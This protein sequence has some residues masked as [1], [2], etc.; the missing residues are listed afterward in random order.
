MKKILIFILIQLLILPQAVFAVDLR[1][2]TDLPGLLS[3]KLQLPNHVLQGI[4][5]KSFHPV[6]NEAEI[7]AANARS[8]KEHEDV[9]YDFGRGL[10]ARDFS[11]KDIYIAASVILDE[12]YAN[13]EARDDYIPVLRKNAA[14]KKL[15][16]L[17]IALFIELF[18][19]AE[20]HEGKVLNTVIDKIMKQ[21][22]IE[23]SRAELATANFRYYV[24]LQNPRWAQR[25]WISILHELGHNIRSN[26]IGEGEEQFHD[27]H[28]ASINEFFADLCPYIVCLKKNWIDLLKIIKLKSKRKYEKAKRANKGVLIDPHL[29]SQSQWYRLFR[30]VRIAS[31]MKNFPRLVS[32]FHAA[33]SEKYSDIK[34]FREWIYQ[35]NGFGEKIYKTMHVLPLDEEEITLADLSIADG[36]EEKV[37]EQG[38]RLH[39][40]SNGLG[41]KYLRGHEFVIESLR[42]T[43]GDGYAPQQYLRAFELLET[44]GFLKNITFWNANK[45]QFLYD[46][47][48][49]K[50]NAQ[51][52]KELGVNS[53]II[54]TQ[55]SK[56]SWRR[57]DFSKFDQTLQLINEMKIQGCSTQEIVDEINRRGLGNRWGRRGGRWTVKAIDGLVTRHSVKSV[58][59]P[60]NK[61]VYEFKPQIIIHGR[62]FAVLCQIA[63]M[64]KHNEGININFKI[65]NEDKQEIINSDTALS[66]IDL[67]KEFF[68]RFVLPVLSRQWQFNDQGQEKF[69]I[70]NPHYFQF[71]FMSE[72]GI[73][74]VPREGIAVLFNRFFS[75]TLKRKDNTSLDVSFYTE[76]TKDV[77]ALPD[78]DIEEIAVGLGYQSSKLIS[79][80]MSEIIADKGDVFNAY[81]KGVQ[82]PAATC[83]IGLT[84]FIAQ[85]I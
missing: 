18:K 25:L 61:N 23:N 37:L 19:N 17:S 33:L 1:E 65:L 52:G 41:Q 24:N 4:Y 55:L 54:A 47:I 77:M 83:M 29:A 45:L 20:F 82:L 10:K 9:L 80:K 58:R 66:D 69:A 56:L 43:V 78:S 16:I 60:Y 39:K 49:K 42:A 76:E 22:L 67:P 73:A 79:G 5:E 50:T 53:K 34:I 8:F 26:V 31:S 6:F 11:R 72:D 44:A 13:K 64:I 28:I 15:K 21:S 2:Q 85:S 7:L 27:R 81:L 68:L 36:F 71:T 40:I 57:E 48:T 59:G 63:K 46:N 75:N 32:I 70:K 62:P 35:I 51:L 14:D 74:V 84:A 30:G 12:L 3:P 38:K